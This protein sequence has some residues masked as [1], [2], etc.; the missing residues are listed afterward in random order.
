MC[1]LVLLYV[2][3]LLIDILFLV[4]VSVIVIINIPLGAHEDIWL[5]KCS[6]H[7]VLVSEFLR[8]I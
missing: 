1:V 3:C 7:D 4:S 2:Y 8:T 6:W 5:I